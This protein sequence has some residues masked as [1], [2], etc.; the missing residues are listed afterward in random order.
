VIVRTVS[1]FDL[2][3][4]TAQTPQDLAAL[5][6]QRLWYDLREE[7]E[8]LYFGE[9]KQSGF[10]H[11]HFAHLTAGYDTGYYSYLAYASLSE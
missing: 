3:I 10:D 5:N 7:L 6:I 2:V 8:G 4:H 9:A 11:V 1:I